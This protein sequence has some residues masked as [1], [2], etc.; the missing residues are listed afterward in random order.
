MSNANRKKLRV[1]AAAVAAGA[2]VAGGA[3]LAASWM[4]TA[5]AAPPSPRAR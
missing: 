2:V 3:T 1:A 4:G 5:Q